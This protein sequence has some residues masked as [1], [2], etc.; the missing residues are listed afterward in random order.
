MRT[1]N[2][3]KFGQKLLYIANRITTRTKKAEHTYAIIQ[4]LNL[5]VKSTLVKLAACT[6]I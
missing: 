5:T 4:I 1:S 3:V 6:I 2:R